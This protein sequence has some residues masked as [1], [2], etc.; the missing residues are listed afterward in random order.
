MYFEVDMTNGLIIF[1]SRWFGRD[2]GL[3]KVKP[4]GGVQ[5][6]AGVGQGEVANLI[7]GY[8]LHHLQPRG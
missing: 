5:A 6:E 1:V 8:L 7:G 4:Q 2:R 3:A